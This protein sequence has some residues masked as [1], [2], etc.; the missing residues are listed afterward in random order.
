MQ[1]IQIAPTSKGTKGTVKS[2]LA[3]CPSTPSFFPRG[4]RVV[5]LATLFFLTAYM[6]SIQSYIYYGI[7][8]N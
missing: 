7:L 4:N 2:L 5:I 1:Y 8:F 3:T 6:V